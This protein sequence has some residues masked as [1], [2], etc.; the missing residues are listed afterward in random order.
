MILFACLEYEVWRLLRKN[1]TAD[2]R[3]LHKSLNKTK[4][5]AR[6]WAVKIERYRWIVLILHIAQ[7][8]QLS[9]C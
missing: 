6:M 1:R 8:M 2:K 9:R 3:E 4:V 5:Q 7:N